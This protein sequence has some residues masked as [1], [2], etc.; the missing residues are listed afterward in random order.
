MAMRDLDSRAEPSKTALGSAP[1]A[2][3]RLEAVAVTLTSLVLMGGRRYQPI[4]MMASMMDSAVPRV[5]VVRPI[6]EQAHLPLTVVRLQQVNLD[7]CPPMVG[8]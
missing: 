7:I 2:A 5:L 3:I 8:L 1:T 4:R 6:L